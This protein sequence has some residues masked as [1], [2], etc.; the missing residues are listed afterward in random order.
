MPDCP[1]DFT[2]VIASGLSFTLY[3][4]SV[5]LVASEATMN[6]TKATMLSA[7]AV[8]ANVIGFMLLDTFPKL[9]CPLFHSFVIV[10]GFVGSPE[11]GDKSFTS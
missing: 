11:N 1:L 3:V 7:S 8:V 9:N 4:P 6:C 10:V 2:T 5:S